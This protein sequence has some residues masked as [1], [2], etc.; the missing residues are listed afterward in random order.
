M[1][2]RE[3]QVVKFCAILTHRVLLKTSTLGAE[4]RAIVTLSADRSPC[5]KS[6]S[7]IIDVYYSQRVS[8]YAGGGVKIYT[9]STCSNLSFTSKETE[10]CQPCQ[11]HW[12]PMAHSLNI[13][14]FLQCILPTSSITFLLQNR[15][16]YS[17]YPRG[18]LVQHFR[19]FLQPIH[20]F[21]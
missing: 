4:R 20:S 21:N 10:L 5:F 12:Q 6:S 9:V 15:S 3:A 8:V 1:R 16:I 11:T 18:N 19:W 14:F 13:K 17:R 7:G 2:Q